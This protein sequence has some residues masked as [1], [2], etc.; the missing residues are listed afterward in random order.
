[1]FIAFLYYAV[2]RLANR[3][4]ISVRL[5]WI[6]FSVWNFLLDLPGWILVHVGIIQP[7][8]WAEFPLLV[9]AAATQDLVLACMQFVVP[10]AAAE[11]SKATTL[12]KAECAIYYGNTGRGDGLSARR[13][14]P[15][16][17]NVREQQPTQ[18]VAE[19]ALKNGVRGTSMP[20]WQ[21]TLTFDEQ[22]MLTRYVETLFALKEPP[23]WP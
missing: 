16:P 9:D 23:S 15:A 12:L 20:K 6:L 17:T 21:G 3:P 7:L 22:R 14:A 13:L 4:V 11:H 10:L 19:L 18:V 8:E 2:P 1:V 5:G